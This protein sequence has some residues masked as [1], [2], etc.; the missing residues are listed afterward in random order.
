ME[1]FKIDTNRT[2]LNVKDLEYLAAKFATTSPEAAQQIRQFLKA[3]SEGYD[4]ATKRVKN[5]VQVVLDRLGDGEAPRVGAYTGHGNARYDAF[6]DPDTYADV[7]YSGKKKYCEHCHAPLMKSTSSMSKLLAGALLDFPNDPNE[8]IHVQELFDRFISAPG[9]QSKSS[10]FGKMDHWGLIAA[11]DSR[12]TGNWRITQMGLDFRRGKISIPKSVT[13]FRNYIT[14]VDSELINIK[15]IKITVETYEDFKES[16]QQ[17][18]AE[19]VEATAPG[20]I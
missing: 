12:R 11:V 19:D 14:E 6:F 16:M 8:T 9:G 2:A 7:Y 20:M 18:S 1:D 13:T 3:V 5:T 10:N 4:A 17:A 15:D